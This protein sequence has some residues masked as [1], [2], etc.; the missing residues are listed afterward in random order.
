[1]HQ[2]LLRT[3]GRP[4][5][6]KQGKLDALAVPYA[7]AIAGTPARTDL[8]RSR[9]TY[10]LRYRS[11]AVPGARLARGASTVILIP[12]RM[13]P[14]GYRAR[15]RGGRVRSARHARWLTITAASRRSVTVTVTPL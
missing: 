9:R 14:R 6:A 1:M 7:V 2:G 3:A 10:S 15:V 13:Y 4:T 5:S 12:S 8:H 11:V